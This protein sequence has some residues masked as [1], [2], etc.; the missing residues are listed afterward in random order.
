MEEMTIE[1]AKPARDFPADVLGWHDGDTC[2]LFI[3]MGFDIFLKRVV[4]LSNASCPEL[5]GPE[6]ERA[7]A[8]KKRSHFLACP[9][10]RVT[11]RTSFDVTFNR[12][13]GQ[14][15]TEAGED[16]GEILVKEGLAGTHKKVGVTPT[17][18]GEASTDPN[19]KFV[20]GDPFSPCMKTGHVFG[21]NWKCVE[22]GIDA[23]GSKG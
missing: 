3:D 6:K 8:A 19:V 13:L 21:R 11:L 15:L 18:S 1:A 2:T 9:S 4:R 17:T 5:K 12:V 20:V 7:E 22:C 23:R 10:S 16:V 14:I